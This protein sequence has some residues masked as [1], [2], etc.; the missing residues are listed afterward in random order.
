M[1]YLKPEVLYLILLLVAPG[2]LS[3][4]VFNSLVSRG[5]GNKPDIYQSILHSTAIM[6]VLY[7]IVV[8]LWGVESINTQTLLDLITRN[9][10]SPLIA[11]AVMGSASILWGLAYSKF[12]RSNVLK[13]ILGKIAAAVEPPNVFAALLDKKYREKDTPKHF[14]I[15]VKNGDYYI[16]GCVEMFAVEE[17]PRE[18]YLTKVALL[19]NNREVVRKFSDNVGVIIK[20]DGYDLLEIAVVN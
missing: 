8:L 9:R 17:N 10:W 20:I 16:E 7:P 2:L 1:S 3:M 6:T 4:T 18:I 5:K 14:W 13:R 15:T 11:A 12:Y 19:D